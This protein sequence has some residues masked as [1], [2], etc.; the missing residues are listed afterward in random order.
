[1]RATVLISTRNRREELPAAIESCLMQREPL[2]V[3]V[4][5]DGSTDGTSEM[6]AARYPQVELVRFDAPLGIVGVRNAV[7]PRISTP[8]FFTLDDDAKFS[9]P[10]VAGDTL[11]EFDHPRVA[12]V[13]IPL[14][15]FIGGKR[16]NEAWRPPAGGGVYAVSHFRGG[17]DCMRLSAFKEVGGYRTLFHRQGEESDLTM[18]LM[19]LG[20]IARLGDADEV[21]H[22]PSPSRNLPEIRFH[23]ARNSL[24]MAAQLVG[25]PM[26]LVQMGGVCAVQARA[27]MRDGLLW[28]AMRGLGAGLVGAARH[29][30]ERKPVSGIVYRRVRQ[31]GGTGWIRL[32]E[33]EGELPALRSV[34]PAAEVGAVSGA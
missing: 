30:P 33:L 22:F 14:V 4:A 16:V 13:T 28:P 7:L 29:W 12:V 8:F 17:A 31:M 3:L 18:R 11:A 5:D 10:D 19:H 27:G 6:V 25:F 21:H 15:N 9:T 2:T 26:V 1:M 20:Y 23:T 32:E 24:L 34:T